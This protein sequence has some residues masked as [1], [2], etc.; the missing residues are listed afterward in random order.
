MLTTITLDIDEFFHLPHIVRRGET[1][2]STGLTKRAGGKG[3][4]QAYAVGRAGGQVELDGA[5][6]DD[7]MWVKE[8]LESA[9]VGTDKL[10]VVKDEVTGRA[11][12]QSAADGENSI[13]K[14]FCLQQGYG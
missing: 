4:N 13:G 12:I 3:A 1:I 11:V 10:K 7:G 8:M 2:S 14:P 9:G 6:G 5:I